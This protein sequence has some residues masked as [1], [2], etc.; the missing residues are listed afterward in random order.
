MHLEAKLHP[1]KCKDKYCYCEVLYYR[2][3]NHALTEV[4][5]KN[6]LFSYHAIHFTPR[7]EQWEKFKLLFVSFIVQLSRLHLDKRAVNSKY[8]SI[9]G[10]I[11]S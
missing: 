8:H 1:Y 9:E 7:R 6:L 10:Q 11:T 4:K 5:A 2:R 3:R